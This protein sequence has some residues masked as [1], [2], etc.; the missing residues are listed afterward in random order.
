MCCYKLFELGACEAARDQQPP[1]NRLRAI[2]H[3]SLTL[4]VR[5]DLARAN[6][7]VMLS[8]SGK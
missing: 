8:L 7:S 6:S 3:E 2:F 5:C 1:D 4:R